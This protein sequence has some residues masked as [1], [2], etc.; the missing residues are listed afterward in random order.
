MLGLL[1][2]EYSVLLIFITIHCVCVVFQLKT[3][4]V[5]FLCCCTKHGSTRISSFYIDT[6]CF[7]GFHRKRDQPAVFHPEGSAAFIIGQLLPIHRLPDHTSLQQGSGVDRLLPPGVSVSH[8]GAFS[9]LSLSHTRT[10]ANSPRPPS[11]KTHLHIGTRSVSGL[12][13]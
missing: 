10:R 5:L 7:H 2:V 4:Y 8:T 6:V 13:C 12:Q 9:S 1:F 11:V 3:S